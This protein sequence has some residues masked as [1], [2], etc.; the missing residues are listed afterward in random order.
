MLVMSL[1]EFIYTVMKCRTPLD[2]GAGSTYV[3]SDLISLSVENQN[4]PH[5]TFSNSKNLN[6]QVTNRWHK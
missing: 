6:L 2:T 3:S 4:V 5:N 1:S